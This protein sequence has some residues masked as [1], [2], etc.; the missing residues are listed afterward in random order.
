MTSLHRVPARGCAPT[1][2]A[3]LAALASVHAAD[4]REVPPEFGGRPELNLS[5]NNAPPPGKDAKPLKPSFDPSLRAATHCGEEPL[6]QIGWIGEEDDQTEARSRERARIAGTGGLV[7][8]RG[9][10]LEVTPTGAA[11]LAFTDWE[12]AGSRT[13]EGDKRWYWYAG[14]MPGSDYLRVEVHY[15]HDAPGSY[16]IQPQTGALAYVHHGDKVGAVAGDGAHVATFDELN[17]PHRVEIAAMDA[18]GPRVEMECRF[19]GAPRGWRASTCGWLDAGRFQ[20]AWENEGGLRVL[21][22]MRVREKKWQVVV[23]AEKG[24]VEMS[25]WGYRKP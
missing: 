23:G 5:D 3:A 24:V 8:R 18:T 20:L 2:A 19:E 16:L 25:C 6:G 13:A 9:K 4:A 14:T 11:P 17:D 22:E 7:A 10:R 21:F 1:L 12:D 15:G